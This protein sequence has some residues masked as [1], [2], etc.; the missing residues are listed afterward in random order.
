MN[1]IKIKT[2]LSTHTQRKQKSN[3]HAHTKTHTHTHRDADH[4]TLP[5]IL[6]ASSAVGFPSGFTIQ[7]DKSVGKGHKSRLSCLFK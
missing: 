4:D 1:K 3:T 7:M 6:A 5:H 2:H